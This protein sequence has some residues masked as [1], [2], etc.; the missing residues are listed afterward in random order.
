MTMWNPG[1]AGIFL[2]L[3]YLAVLIVWVLTV[4]WL[5][6]FAVSWGIRRA[7]RNPEIEERLTAIIR[8]AL[9]Q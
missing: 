3:A 6:S 1:L 9:R 8:N 4:I 2:L 7:L 5:V